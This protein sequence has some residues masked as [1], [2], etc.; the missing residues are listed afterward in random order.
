MKSLYPFVFAWLLRYAPRKDHFGAAVAHLLYGIHNRILRSCPRGTTCRAKMHGFE[1]VLPA[2]H[3]LPLYLADHPHQEK[4]LLDLVAAMQDPASPDGFVMVDV[5]ANIGDT[6]I[7]SALRAPE[8]TF[9]CIEGSRDYFPYLVE[10][11]ARA[12]MTERFHLREMLCGEPEDVDRG[13]SIET[14][15]GTGVVKRRSGDGNT[16][17]PAVATL[18]HILGDAGMRDRIGLIKIDTDGFDYRVL[19]GAR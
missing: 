9:L 16:E 15:F 13:F 19:R 3:L 11:V 8:G 5:G 7:P 2:G 17:G 14:N 1:F 6:A 10:N 12:G 4:P 18:D